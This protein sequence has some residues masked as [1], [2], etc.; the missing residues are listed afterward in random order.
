[1]KPIF[2]GDPPFKETPISVKDSNESGVAS[3]F[4]IE[5]SH[6]RRPWPGTLRCRNASVAVLAQNVGHNRS[7][8]CKHHPQIVISVTILMILFYFAFVFRSLFFCF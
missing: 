1:L 4:R 8:P 3:K 5:K 7:D 6:G 2:L